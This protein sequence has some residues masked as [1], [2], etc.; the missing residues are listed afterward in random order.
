MNAIGKNIRQIRINKN[1]RQEELAD[2]LFVTRQTISNYETGRSQPDVDTLTRIAEILETD[3]HVLIYGPPVPAEKRSARIRLIVN[4]ILLAVLA[5]VCGILLPICKD[6]LQRKYYIAP[7]LLMRLTLRPALLFLLGW[8]GMQLIATLTGLK[9]KENRTVKFIRTVLYVV[10]GLLVILPLPYI[11]W[12]LVG[13][14]QF[15]TTRSVS[16]VFPNIPL[17]TPLL[18]GLIWLHL[19]SPFFV[20]L[21]GVLCPLMGIP[22]KKKDK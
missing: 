17:Y 21:F 8:F 3:I 16:L 15:L 7:L 2:A 9:A 4:G 11:V 19:E 5:I 14:I 10:L 18:N 1:M 12:L 22:G 13:F 6:I 20:T